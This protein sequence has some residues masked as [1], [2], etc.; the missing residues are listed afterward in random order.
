[1]C[2]STGSGPVSP[3]KNHRWAFKSNNR[4]YPSHIIQPPLEILKDYNTYLSVP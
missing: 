3:N 1:M 2:N 4:I